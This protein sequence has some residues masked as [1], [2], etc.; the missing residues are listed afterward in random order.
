MNSK[1]VV[2]LKDSTLQGHMPTIMITEIVLTILN[3]HTY[4]KALWE[5]SSVQYT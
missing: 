2:V 5:I 1:S 4:Y 3:A